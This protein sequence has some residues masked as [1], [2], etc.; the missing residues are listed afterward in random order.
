MAEDAAPQM[1]GEQKDQ[2]LA[3]KSGIYAEDSDDED[4]GNARRSAQGT[5]G[6]GQD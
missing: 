3:L 6:Q 2:G 1:V 5:D 4:V